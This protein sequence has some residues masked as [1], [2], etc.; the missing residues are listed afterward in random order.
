MP[1]TIIMQV[2]WW[3]VCPSAPAWLASRMQHDEFPEPGFPG[4]R[5]FIHPGLETPLPARRIY[6]YKNARRFGTGMKL[7]ARILAF[8][9][10]MLILAIADRIGGEGEAP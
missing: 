4:A 2:K 8:A 9:V 5:S 6:A 3:Q 10:A 1:V 7:I